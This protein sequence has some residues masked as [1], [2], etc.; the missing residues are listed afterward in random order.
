MHSQ[1]CLHFWSSITSKAN[2]SITTCYSNSK[3]FMGPSTSRIVVT[4]MSRWTMGWH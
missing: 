3:A 4:W 1:F 2:P